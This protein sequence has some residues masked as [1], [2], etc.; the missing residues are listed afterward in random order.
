[1]KPGSQ[2]RRPSRPAGFVSLSR[3]IDPLNADTWVRGLSL[4]QRFMG[5]T[6]PR[7]PGRRVGALRR[8]DRVRRDLRA[9]LGTHVDGL[10]HYSWDGKTYNG[11]PESD[12]TSGHGAKSL[13]VH[14]AEHGFVT[15]GV[16]LDIAA[17]HG[18]RWLDRG[19]GSGRRNSRRPRQR[20]ASGCAPVTR[21]LIHTRQRRGDPDRGPRC[22]RTSS[23]SGWPPRQLPAVP[24]GA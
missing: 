12:T 4:V 3:D 15:R 14:H 18:V 9:R 23:S 21:A 17:L 13:S 22:D 2:P 7:P 8:G 6:R 10:A 16:L 20:R 24:E 11:F 19:H 1:M 5:C